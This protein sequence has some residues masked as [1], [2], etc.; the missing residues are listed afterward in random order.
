MRDPQGPNNEGTHHA[1]SSEGLGPG[2]RVRVSCLLANGTNIWAMYPAEYLCVEYSNE[3]TSSIP[4]E[5][6]PAKKHPKPL[7][8][9]SREKPLY[10][11]E[12][13]KPVYCPFPMKK[14]AIHRHTFSRYLFY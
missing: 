9:R 3:R 11:R 1:K 10:G 6:Q 7:P 2:Q 13:F 14:T 12:I 4:D 5:P 8:P